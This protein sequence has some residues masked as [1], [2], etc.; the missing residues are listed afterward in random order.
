MYQ[1]TL[2]YFFILPDGAFYISKDT[3]YVSNDTL[4]FLCIHKKR[5]S[6]YNG[7]QTTTDTFVDAGFFMNIKFIKTYWKLI[8]NL[9]KTYWKLIKTSW[10]LIK[11][12]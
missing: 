10:K 3:F 12:F 8:R 5:T 7:S 4:I 2:F 9:L 11:T 6:L 1:M